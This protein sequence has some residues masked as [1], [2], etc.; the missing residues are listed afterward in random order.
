MRMM[1]MMNLP[2]PMR[3]LLLN[4]YV[5]QASGLGGTMLTQT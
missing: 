5:S 1:R 2:K 4:Q 3:Q